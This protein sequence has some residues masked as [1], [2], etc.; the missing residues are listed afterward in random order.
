MVATLGFFDLLEIGVELFLFGE[1]GRV[2]ARQHRLRGIA[3]PVGARHLHQLDGRADLAGRRHV[4]T[5]AEIEPVALPIDRDALIS[6]NRLNEFDLEGFADLFEIRDRLVAAPFLAHDRF[7]A[8]DDLAHLL[9]DRRQ[10]L[11]RKGRL[12]P[13]I[14]IEA[15]LDHRPDGDLRAG[16]QLLHGLGENVRGVVADQFERARVLAI[17]ELDLRILFDRLNDVDELAVEGHRDGALG[18]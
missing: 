17:D 5:T 14:V 2:D 1:G 9:L 13:E 16:K 8:R 10:V 4:R 7:V 6:G 12:A 3:A 15:V 11:G 18:E